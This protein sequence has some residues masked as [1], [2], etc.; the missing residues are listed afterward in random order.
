MKIM[1]K[2]FYPL[3]GYKDIAVNKTKKIQKILVILKTLPEFQ[4]LIKYNSI[5]DESVRTAANYME[6][7]KINKD[8]YIFKQGNESDAFY[9][10]LRGKISI[11][12][13][14]FKMRET[15]ISKNNK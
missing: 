7:R 8:K 9:C 15:I 12:K 13:Q 14:T 5:N 6:Y 10:I 1:R 11:R 3:E 4:K 2:S